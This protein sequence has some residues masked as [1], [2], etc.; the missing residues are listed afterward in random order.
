MRREDFERRFIEEF[1]GPVASWLY[2]DDGVIIDDV[3]FQA[4]P[5][6]TTLVVT[7]R[8][9]DRTECRFGYRGCKLFGA[10]LPHQEP[11]HV[12]HDVRIV[13]QEDV[14]PGALLGA[15]CSPGETAWFD[16]WTPPA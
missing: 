15:T 1:K 14:Q 4:S 5:E 8:H 13:F 2:E 12:A 11:E 3:R 6:E 9:K 10:E 16:A 7:F